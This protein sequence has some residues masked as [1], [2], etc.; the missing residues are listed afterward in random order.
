MSNKPL[1]KLPLNKK[2]WLRHRSGKKDEHEKDL[3]KQALILIG[4]IILVFIAV[5]CT[6]G[7][8]VSSFSLPVSMSALFWVWLP[9]TVIASIVAMRFRGKGLLVLF[10]PVFFLF[11][12]SA[13]AIIDGGKWVIYEISIQYNN[14][15]PV[16]VLFPESET[17]SGTF[18]RD[19]FAFITIMGA[20]I[21][22]FLAFSICLRRSLFTTIAITAPIIFLTFVITDLVADLIFLYGLIAVYLT[23][24]ISSAVS[25]ED[26]FKRGLRF[27]PSF[28]VAV[29]IMIIAYMFAPYN[30]Y[31]REEQIA[32]MGNRFRTV[33]S[34]MGRFG[35]LWQSTS[36]MSVEI[37]WLGALGTGAWHFNTENVS[38]ADAGVR[39][40]HNQNLLEITASEPGTF[41]LRG[42]SMQH[43]NGRSWEGNSDAASV[44]NAAESAQQS[45]MLAKEM[46]ALIADLYLLT[47]QNNKPVKVEMDIIRTGDLTQ[48]I[49]YQPYYS[50]VFLHEQIN[51][52]DFY[53]G[54][55]FYYGGAFFQEQPDAVDFRS[56]QEFY[57]VEDS[58][59]KLAE[60]IASTNV[61]IISYVDRSDTN[62]DLDVSQMTRIENIT[63][64]IITDIDLRDEHWWD[65][66][67]IMASTQGVVL[68]GQVF[69]PTVFLSEYLEQMQVNSVYT[70]VDSD[71]AQRL[72]Q[73]A[74]DAGINLAADRVEIV[75]A[76]ARYI[77]SSAE[78]S[79]TP[80][81]TPADEDF[82]LYFLDTLQEGY[83]I[84]FA[85][86]AV[87]MLRSL[88]IP[89]RF[90]SGYVVRVLPGDVGSTVVLTDMNAHAWVEVYYEDAGWLY[91]EVTP[92]GGGTYIP[93]SRPHSP[94]AP[95]PIPQPLQLPDEPD[96]ISDGIPDDFL[97]NT[98]S[99][100]AVTNDRD[101]HNFPPWVTNIG[102]LIAI[103]FFL[104]ISLPLRRNIASKLRTRNFEQTNANKAVI[105]IWKYINKVGSRWF[106]PP[107]NIEELALKARF[108][109][110]RLT[111]GER[112]E[113]I[114][115]AKRLAYEVCS[116]KDGPGRLWM[117]Y[118]RGL[119]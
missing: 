58:I 107:G 84:H 55:Q 73:L 43:F 92:S 106:V 97:I 41:Y 85:T 72:R 94:D 3:N 90:T 40:I 61:A 64:V 50:G 69:N 28:A 110:H 112:A 27:L 46:P 32:A 80:G 105:Y 44:H 52:I 68:A 87:L 6:F 76:V 11:L 116:G 2:A 74:V 83:C 51:T 35:Q 93:E 31:S 48:S 100:G 63:T 53:A 96:M 95:V 119:C 104:T 91:L 113:M 111:E 30:T 47:H 103:T 114:K 57:Y 59:H 71:T 88:D 9:C 118:I 36:G 39:T 38:V 26:Y 29:V 45:Y 49:N 82:A 67:E 10:I 99:P 70:E 23:L 56:A 60:E 109:Q 108:S 24:L 75:D 22:L 4:N 13:E 89:A 16:A 17:I 5:F 81:Q 102:V 1:P 19:L 14:W 66:D 86:A 34:Q 79:L 25:P 77:K 37:G 117:K 8:L 115:Y 54:R 98:E 101:G 21:T 78:Y 15:L 42:Y 20:V 18:D 62:V 12:L 65:S 33:A 7:A